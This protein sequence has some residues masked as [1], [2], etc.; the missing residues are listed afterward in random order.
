MNFHFSQAQKHCVRLF[1]Y[2]AKYGGSQDYL[3]SFSDEQS[4]ID[5]LAQQNVQVSRI[6]ARKNKLFRAAVYCLLLVIPFGTIIVLG[7]GNLESEVKPLDRID[8]QIEKTI[9]N[10]RSTETCQN[11]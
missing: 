10:T 8:I 1:F 5:D 2:I 3:Q 6:I 11:P 7:G 9:I 4:M